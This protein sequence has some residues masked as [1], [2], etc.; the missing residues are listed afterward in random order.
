MRGAVVE[1]LEWLGY[2]AESHRKVASS[3]LTVAIRRLEK[4]LCQPSS[5][6]VP[7]SNQ[8][9]IMQWKER[10]GLRLSSAVI[11]IQRVSNPH[12]P[13]GYYAMGN[14]YPFTQW[15]HMLWC[16]IRTVS[17]TAGI[18]LGQIWGRMSAPIFLNLELKF[19]KI[20]KTSQFLI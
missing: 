18:F 13:Y 11:K 20:K 14:L 9:R 4:S 8:G 19:P 12:C 16:F 15:K 7:S 10:D 1:W 3:R 5:K 6:W 17:A 2:C